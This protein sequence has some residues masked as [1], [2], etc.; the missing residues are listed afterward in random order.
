LGCCALFA[1]GSE[2]L[3]RAIPPNSNIERTIRSLLQVAYLSP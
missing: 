2:S 3:M 1:V